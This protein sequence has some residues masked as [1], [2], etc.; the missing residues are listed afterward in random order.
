MRSYTVAVAAFALDVDIKW[1]D[2]VLSHHNVRG[3]LRKRQGI[4]RQILPE[5]LLI[6]AIAGALIDALGLPIA[7][8]IEVAHSMTET[9]ASVPVSRTISLHADLDSIAARLQDRLADAIEGAAQKRRGR[10]V[11]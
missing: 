3:V 1:L 5:S 9:G 8:A 11:G 7:R 6:L 2:N 10:P 4:Q